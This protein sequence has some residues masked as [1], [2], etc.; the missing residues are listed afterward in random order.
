MVKSGTKLYIINKG[1]NSVSVIDSVLKKVVNTISV[2]KSP[3][4][5]LLMAGKL[6]ITNSAD[7]TVSI[8][9][10]AT[11]TVVQTL[12]TGVE[13]YQSTVVNNNLYVYNKGNK[14]FSIIPS[15]VPTLQ[16]LEAV[17]KIGSYGQGQTLTLR[18]TFNRVILTG[19]FMNLT[20]NNGVK[21]VL[22]KVNNNT[23]SGTYLIEKNQ[24]IDML[25]VGSIDAS[26]IIDFTAIE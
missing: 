13:P 12:A 11:D 16:A 7:N 9:D 2:G 24:E 5:S 8:I 6:Y 18:A 3:S 15:S 26:K 1:S 4:S 10:V 21:V 25:N 23:I 17:E 22:D 20:L 19:S 14:S